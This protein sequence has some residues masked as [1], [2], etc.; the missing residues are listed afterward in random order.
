MEDSMLD[1]LFGGDKYAAM[2]RALDAASL[3]QQVISHNLANA[4]TPNYK[5]QE[6]QFE[7]QLARALAKANDPCAPACEPV[8]TLRPRI[9]TLNTTS[10]RTDGNN[11][12]MELEMSNLSIN[13][14][15]YEGITQSVGG[16]F[17]SLKNVIS[18]GR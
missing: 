3:R 9:V 17:S 1:K 13:T 7:S 5:R 15:R 11:V 10:T 12:N 6:V 8:S 16:Y 2:T 18:G 14:L 4:N